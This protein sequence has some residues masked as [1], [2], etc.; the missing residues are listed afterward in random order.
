MA[1]LVL[2]GAAIS[3]ARAQCVVVQSVLVD[4]CGQGAEGENEAVFFIT[5]GT[6]SLDLSKMSVVWP[7]NG[8]RGLCRDTMTA[9]KTAAFNR[10]I[11]GG[12]FLMEPAADSIPA[13]SKVLLLTSTQADTL[14][15]IFTALADTVYII[16]QCAGNTA[17]H[18][19]N[20]SSTGVNKTVSLRP[21][22]AGCSNS[23]LS[24]NT[25]SLLKANGTGGAEDGAMVFVSPKGGAAYGNAHCLSPIP[26]MLSGGPDKAGCVGTPIL[27]TGY[28][29]GHYSYKWKGGKGIF[30]SAN[31]TV[32]SY[33]PAENDSDKIT[34]RL[35]G[36]DVAG[37]ANAGYNVVITIGRAPL[38]QMP[39][40]T[41]YTC[42]D[43]PLDIKSTISNYSSVEW[44]AANN[45]NFAN[46]FVAAPEYTLRASDGNFAV[47][48]VSSIN[49]CGTRQDTIVIALSKAPHINAGNDTF[50]CKGGTLNLHGVV[51]RY[52]KLLWSSSG[53]GSF[54][55]PGS[56]TPTYKLSP[57]DTLPFYIRLWADNGSCRSASDSFR[58]MFRTIPRGK[59]LGGG[60]RC[61]DSL[62]TPYQGVSSTGKGY[63]THNGRGK[64]IYANDTGARYIPHPADSLV[65]VLYHP[66]GDCVGVPD[67]SRTE[68]RS[69]TIADAGA[70][71]IICAGQQ[72]TLDGK[73]NGTSFRWGG[74]FGNFVP[75][76]SINP[77][78]MP[79]Q[80]DTGTFM[81]FLEVNGVCGKKID[82]VWVRQRPALFVYAGKD[83][84]LC[85][86]KVFRLS[87]QGSATNYEWEIASGYGKIT[88]HAGM[89]AQYVPDD[90]DTTVK[91][92]VEGVNPCGKVVDTLVLS[93]LPI[94]EIQL[95]LRER[96]TCVSRPVYAQ[97]AS[98]LSASSVKWSI[99]EGNGV[100]TDSTGLSATYVPDPVL[101][102]ARARLLV[103]A[104]NGCRK[105]TDTMTIHFT[106]ASELF[107]LP[108]NKA[109]R[110]GGLV[111]RWNTPVDSMKIL[112]AEGAFVQ[113]S[114]T[115][116]IYYPRE[117]DS[118][119][120]HLTI[121]GYNGCGA[122]ADS[123]SVIFHPRVKA[124]FISRPPQ[125]VAYGE[126]IK[127]ESNGFNAT[128]HFWNFGDGSKSGGSE[129]E[130]IYTM[131]GD[132]KVLLRVV[133]P[134]LCEDTFSRIIR[135]YLEKRIF[136]PN[137]FS[138]NNDMTNDRF[139][140]FTSGAQVYKL[141]ISN[142]WGQIVHETNDPQNEWDGRYNG[143]I[144]M[145]GV[146]IY[147]ISIR[148]LDYEK[149]Y[150]SGTL[151]IFN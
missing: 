56:L 55:A 34:L 120:S 88:G 110:N 127:F 124:S 59:I 51:D 118:L 86:P 33:T 2:S 139:R 132:K 134:Q 3:Q 140:V 22:V 24:Y 57:A 54:S 142:R 64:F 105:A 113:T 66:V 28:G 13:G 84:T 4:A 82:T 23:N 97:A 11:A 96:H 130:H 129:T 146:Y 29:S 60:L 79:S 71:K 103:T 102:G 108:V 63:F 150:Y 17:D 53:K 121:V 148:W 38:I 26:V 74:G 104:D 136:I 43:V 44:N 112:N 116:A 76:T 149:S 39:A 133:S 126:S 138:P 143:E 31:K 35:V 18:F 69:A 87:A 5:T 15:T 122:L 45:N 135:V 36:Y 111:L 48:T 85:K 114:D 78:Y 101:D 75:N 8:W 119:K 46:R 14:S 10:T 68:F 77:T 128:D 52:T 30:S 92:Y 125:K 123:F 6:K 89:Q 141:V 12:G 1:A 27:L 41:L 137:A 144:V 81:L 32:T 117:E 58:V 80:K 40:D 21:N 47:L 145:P 109:C 106:V 62:G 100:L 37:N 7:A 16:Y 65:T 99:L 25:G 72:F 67:T 93:F 50:V 19:P 147:Q 107:L 151:H 91:L 61:R 131:L 49:S 42:I 83:S 73:Y 90:R 98:N 115:S 9:R 20:Y 94:P 95:S 70:D